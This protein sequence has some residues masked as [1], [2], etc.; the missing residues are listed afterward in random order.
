MKHLQVQKVFK[1]DQR[2]MTCPWFVSLLLAKSPFHWHVQLHPK[3]PRLSFWWLS[4][5]KCLLRKM[6]VTIGTLQVDRL[7]RW[8]IQT[9]QGRKRSALPHIARTLYGQSEEQR[10]IDSV[11][12]SSK[13]Y[14]ILLRSSAITVS[15]KLFARPFPFCICAWILN[16]ILQSHVTVSSSASAWEKA[17][18]TSKDLGQ[19]STNRFLRIWWLR[20]LSSVVG[21]MPAYNR[22]AQ[23]DI[24]IEAI[25]AMV[26]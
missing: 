16:Y 14:M 25:A 7:I 23:S 13:L 6:A 17:A 2:L 12:V 4:S 26:L 5:V 24:S 1:D 21:M 8:F 11:R 19:S 10:L 3:I 20:Q 18:R 9:R 22:S 15:L